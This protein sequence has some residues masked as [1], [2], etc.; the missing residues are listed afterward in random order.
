MG[1]ETITCKQLGNYH[2]FDL[3]KELLKLKRLKGILQKMPDNKQKYL[4]LSNYRLY[5]QFLQNLY[6]ANNFPFKV[7]NFD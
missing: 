7:Y 1:K 2:A 3:E 5:Y 6:S 4:L